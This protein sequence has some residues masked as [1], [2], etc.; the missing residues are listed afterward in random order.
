MVL[1]ALS[2]AKNRRGQSQ[3]QQQTPNKNKVVS[4][5]S[6]QPK[7]NVQQAPPTPMHPL[8][9]LQMHEIRLGQMEKKL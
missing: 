4:A 6:C 3:S 8:Q 9:A 1:A 7:G 5:Q 2:A